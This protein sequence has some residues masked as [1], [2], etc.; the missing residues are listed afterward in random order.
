MLDDMVNYEIKIGKF[1]FCISQVSKE[2][3]L[4]FSS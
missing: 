4:F 2:D 1:D 3:L